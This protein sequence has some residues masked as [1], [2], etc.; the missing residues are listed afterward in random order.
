MVVIPDSDIYLLKSPLQIDNKNQLTFT[1]ATAQYNYFSSLTKLE[2]EGAT[3]QRKDGAIRFEGNFEDLIQYN[4]CMYKNTHYKNKWF[5]AFIIG[6]E[7]KNDNCTFIYIKTDVWQSWQFDIVYN[8]SYVEREMINV[9]DDV[10]GAN[11]VPE[12]LE[13]GEY[14]VAASAAIANLEPAFIFA[15]TGD[16]F[17]TVKASGDPVTCDLSLSVGDGFTITNGLPNPHIYYLCAE[18]LTNARLIQQSLAQG[19]QSEKIVAAFTVPKLAVNN[20]KKSLKYQVSATTYDLDTYIYVLEGTANAATETLNSTPTTLD[21]YSPKNAK[22]R[23]FP[24]T[25]LGYNPPSGTSKVYRYENFTNGTPS[26]K[27]ISE[28]NP[29]PTVHFIPQNYRGAS[30]NSLCDNVTLNGYPQLATTVDVYNSWLAE[31]SGIIR[32]QQ[33]QANV[34]YELDTMANSIAMF[35]GIG[36]MIGGAVSGAQS[37]QMDSSMFSGFSSTVGSAIALGKTQANYD[38]T[39]G[40]INAQKEKQALLPDNVTLGG[41]NA[42]LLGYNLMDD[43]IFTRYSIKYQFAK[44]ID[45]YF[46]MYGYQ[47]NQLKIPNINNRPQWNYVKLAG[48]N[49]IGEIPETDLQEIKSLFN[50]GITLWHNAT[51]FLDYSQ[52]NRS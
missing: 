25:Y 45:D 43:N 49:L 4:Y 44:R 32:V 12:N 30:G 10:P 38:A 11:L 3:Y 19:N 37:G 23:Q 33:R 8:A 6:M 24:F 46:S 50:E 27:I 21:G 52:N 18:N 40:M 48:A 13:T 14:K 17:Q 47:T 31:N 9:A 7:Y 15:Y 35:T 22:M 5:Y 2:L 16:E 41:S 26:F 51:T 28:I 20:I 34:N 1:N 29:N 39:I 36:N 42:T